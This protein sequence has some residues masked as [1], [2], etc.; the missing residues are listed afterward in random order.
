MK[1][2]YKT[3]SNLA[4]LSAF[5]ILAILPV[6][7]TFGSPNGP[8][9][10]ADTLKADDYST[11]SLSLHGGVL[12]SFTDIK[13]HPLFPGRDE[14]AYGGGISLNY[15]MSPVL[16]LQANVLS[17]EMK[18]LYP[19]E[20]LRF[21]TEILETTLRFRVS[22]NALLNPEGNSQSFM[23]FYTFVGAGMMAYRSVAFENDEPVRFYGY[24][25]DGRTTADRLLEF[26]LPYGLGVNFRLGKRVDLGIES[27]FRYT[28]SD[29][30]DAWPVT[31]SPNDY[32]NYT[33]VGLTFRFGCNTCSMDWA[34]PRRTMYPGDVER[35]DNIELRLREIELQQDSISLEQDSI[36]AVQDSLSA[37]IIQEREV[38]L[39]L[40]QDQEAEAARLSQEVL[41]LRHLAASSQAELDSLSEKL[42]EYYSVQVAALRDEESVGEVARLLGIDQ[43]LR[44]HSAG[45]WHR[46]LSGRFRNLEDAKLQMQRFWGQGV[47]DAFVVKYVDGVYLA[48]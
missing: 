33:S 45:G 39:G 5:L 21:E 23:N 24:E 17:G 1:I 4:I 10:L 27:G 13:K 20:G 9:E 44:I 29:R 30:L 47:R 31:S 28:P 18:G 35:L 7:K 16:S 15:H 3:K 42:N 12:T 46:Y 34:P 2:S 11:F 32:Y 37:A 25:A 36:K 38:L 48:Y 26:V 40:Q 19:S 14:V 22:L 6:S 43:E 41:T 8:E